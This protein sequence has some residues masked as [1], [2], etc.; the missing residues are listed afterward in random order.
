ML[1]AVLRLPALATLPNYAA[2]RPS[3]GM[4]RFTF[5]VNSAYDLAGVERRR[6]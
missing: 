2:S 3:F 5:A 1:A 4:K 6:P